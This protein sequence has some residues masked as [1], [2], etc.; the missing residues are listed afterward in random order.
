MAF[1]AT[2]G[3]SDCRWPGE[4]GSLDSTALGA[5]YC[6]YCCYYSTVLTEVRARSWIYTM[7]S[8][9]RRRIYLRWRASKHIL[10]RSAGHGWCSTCS[11]PASTARRT[12]QSSVY[13]CTAVPVVLLARSL[14]HRK[15]IGQGW[16]WECW[17][18]AQPAKRSCRG[19]NEGENQCT[20]ASMEERKRELN[21][22]RP[23]CRA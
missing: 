8:S 23:E 18:G 7:L 14:S 11:A 19:R 5:G 12:G 16:D 3:I 9:T 4:H 22:E 13:L 1:W 21:K 2:G 10:R 6:Y 17:S 15:L 20:S